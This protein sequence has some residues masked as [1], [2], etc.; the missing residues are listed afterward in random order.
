MKQIAFTLISIFLFSFIAQAQ[1]LD[2]VF[3]DGG[4]SS[5][6]N[7]VSLRLSSLIEGTPT[8]QYERFIGENSGLVINAGLSLYEGFPMTVLVS[9]DI[10]EFYTR[11][12]FL[13]RGFLLGLQYRRYLIDHDGF[14]TAYEAEFQR[15]HSV[16]N[17]YKDNRFTLTFLYGFKWVIKDAYCIT[18]STGLGVIY[19]NRNNT[20]TLDEYVALGFHIPV[21]FSF[22]YQF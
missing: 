15:R 22:T 12:G 20:S 18:L 6:K 4:Q 2:E 17:L 5:F 3:D 8:I 7:S 11:T 1:D 21:R 9:M 13:N 10:K 16:D 14:Y 19:Y